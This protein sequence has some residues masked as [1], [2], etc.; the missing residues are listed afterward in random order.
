MKLTQL[1]TRLIE[2][3]YRFQDREFDPIFI[4]GIA[5]SG[6]TLLSGLLDQNYC[7]ACCIHES[8]LSVP[9]NSPLKIGS[10]ASYKTLKNYYEN[11]F[12]YDMV[13]TRAVRDSLLNFYCQK[14]SYPKESIV[15]FD[16]APNVHLVRTGKLKNAFPDS[17]FLFIFRDPVTSIEGLRRKWPVFREANV[18]EVC[19]FWESVHNIF[20]QDTKKFNSDIRIISYETLTEQ[21]DSILNQL[22]RYCKL[23]RRNKI[24][25]YND[26]S[27]ISGKGLRNVMNGKIKI[28]K[29]S[30]SQS[31]FSLQTRE[32]NFIREKLSPIY[33]KLNCLVKVDC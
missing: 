33:N 30:V 14:T 13:S 28:S 11:M 6:T 32:V 21:T 16:K 5:G 17:K 1:K 24:K 19:N 23:D 3:Y 22:A 10:I 4:C 20:L 12:I 27:D 15:V 8:A 9:D 29:N 31:S 2:L 18:E 26:R 7:N 25:I